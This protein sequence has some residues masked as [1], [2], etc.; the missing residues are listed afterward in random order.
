[1]LSQFT[2]RSVE[3]IDKATAYDN[4][5]T[6]QEAIEFGLCDSIATGFERY[7][8]NSGGDSSGW[9]EVVD[10]TGYVPFE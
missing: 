4:F 6:A 10:E 5:F 2:G 9:Y 3:E 8:E 1:M 7:N